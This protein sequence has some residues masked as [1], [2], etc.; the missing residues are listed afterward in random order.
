VAARETIRCFA[1][2]DYAKVDWRP[3]PGD[4]E[5]EKE[6]QVGSEEQHIGNQPT[7]GLVEA[8]IHDGGYADENL[9]ATK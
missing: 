8:P 4:Q 6:I 1:L 5:F 3:R 2:L 7:P 9:L